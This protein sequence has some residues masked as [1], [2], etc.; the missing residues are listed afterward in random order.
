MLLFLRV[1]HLLIRCL[2]ESEATTQAILDTAPDGIITFDA[3]GAI[4]SLNHAAE[5]L[6]G[7]T[8]DDIVGQQISRLMPALAPAGHSDGLGFALAPGAAH[9]TNG[10]RRD[11]TSF[12]ADIASSETSVGNRRLFTS[13][14]RDIAQRKR[15][16][17]QL[18]Q[19][20]KMQAMGPW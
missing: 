6:F 2:E 14:V 1:N 10:Q 16:E 11:G 7:Y 19:L 13:I 9:E 17:A 5:G 3:S 4:Q 15:L 8:A 20:Q 12:P 18:R